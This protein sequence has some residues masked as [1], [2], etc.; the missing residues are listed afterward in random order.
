MRCAG[1]ASTYP[2]GSF[3]PGSELGPVKGG[4]QTAPGPWPSTQVW[5]TCPPRL[6][7]PQNW[8]SDLLR[9]DIPLTDTN[10]WKCAPKPADALRVT[11]G[12][13]IGPPVCFW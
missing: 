8:V 2:D 9:D 6:L 12:A 3:L 7:H 5:Q 11:T 1:V 4:L 13:S 10:G